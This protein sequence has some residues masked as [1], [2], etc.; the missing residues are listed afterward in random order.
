MDCVDYDE[1]LV[2]KITQL[3]I[4]EASSS[5]VKEK[6]FLNTCELSN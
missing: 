4:S 1:Q 5:T 2:G 3:T 6:E